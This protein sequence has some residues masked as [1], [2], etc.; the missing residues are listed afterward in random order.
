MF[1]SV[2]GGETWFSVN[3]GLPSLY[4][5]AVAVDPVNSSVLYAG[6]YEHKLYKSVDG[7]LS[8]MPAS[9]GIQEKAIV[10]S[11]AIDPQNP[12]N[13]YISTRG[14]P[15]NG[16]AP[17]KGVVYKSRDAGA[18]W[19]TSLAGIGG[20]DKE[21]WVYSLAINPELAQRHFRGIPPAR[22]VPQHRSRRRL[23]VGRLGHRRWVRAGDRHRSAYIQP[24][25]GVLWGM[26]WRRG[27]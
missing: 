8:W 11:I 15:T 18:S 26:A 2:D 27:F 1:K 17:W 6:P 14:I 3:I 24:R 4:I 19:S 16:G 9:E 7:G 20:S 21:D 10:Y 23:G 22:A 5:N 12:A 25:G 13:V